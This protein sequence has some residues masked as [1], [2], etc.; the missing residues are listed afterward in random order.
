MKT[1]VKLQNFNA[2]NLY[3]IINYSIL[4]KTEN[5][6]LFE[7]C[8]I[9]VNYLGG[10]K[11]R[12]EKKRTHNVRLHNNNYKIYWELHRCIRLDSNLMIIDCLISAKPHYQFYLQIT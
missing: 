9:L 6:T 8:G 10:G 5:K 12:K 11:R 4:L 7:T 2:F 1:Q 3:V